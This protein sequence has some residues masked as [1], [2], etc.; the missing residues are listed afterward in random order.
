L[1]LRV[2]HVQGF[3]YSLSVIGHCK[4][5]LLESS[6]GEAMQKLFPKGALSKAVAS[7]SRTL[8]FPSISR[9]SPTLVET[10]KRGYNQLRVLK[11]GK[12]KKWFVGSMIENSS[13]RFFASPRGKAIRSSNS[14][15]F[16]YTRKSHPQVEESFS[17]GPAGT[18]PWQRKPEKRGSLC[19]PVRE[20]FKE[21]YQGK[22]YF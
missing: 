17:G 10:K 6:L 4:L 15:G 7:Q 1:G 20:G 8:K 19:A 2:H 12:W 22:G 11:N 21:S 14:L 18:F 9:A 3:P 16:W 5:H 13:W